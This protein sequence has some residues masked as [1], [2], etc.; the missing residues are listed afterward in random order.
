[1]SLFFNRKSNKIHNSNLSYFIKFIFF[2]NMEIIVFLSLIVLIDMIANKHNHTFD[3]SSMKRYS[4]S[5]QTKKIIKGLAKKVTITVFYEKG[6]RGDND[7]KL[8]LYASES[9]YLKYKLLNLDRNP[10]IAEKYKIL[11]YGEVLIECNGKY[12]KIPS[13][14]ED[15]I[16]NAILWVTRNKENNIYFLKGHGEKNPFSANMKNSYRLFKEALELENYT[17]KTISLIRNNVPADASLLI[18]SG[19]KIDLLE[20]ELENL[21]QYIV[22]GGK[23]IAMIDPFTVPRLVEFFKKYGVFFGNDIIVDKK[24]RL[25]GGS[26]LSPVA[27]LYYQR[28]PITREFEMGTL[29][30]LVRS[31]EFKDESLKGIHGMSLVRTHPDSWAEVDKDSIDHGNSSYQKLEDKK[32]PV[33]VVV[34]VEK[35]QEQ[36]KSDNKK[37]DWAMCF[38]GDSDFANNSNFDILGNKTLI[39]NVISWLTEDKKLI[40]T[41]PQSKRQLSISNL[42]LTAKQNII[43]FWAVVVV[44]PALILFIGILIYIRRLR[45]G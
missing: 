5:D 15:R 7:Q 9:P 3:F 26:Y 30:S 39:L 35:A 4:L 34:L 31:V 19:P 11:T 8:R 32:G 16:V 36:N 17:V 42:F 45:Y 20:E 23:I 40:F 33:S 2:A 25:F 28:H 18:L 43:I 1:M 41:R 27:S 38:F 10:E 21:A 12:K 29:F 44:E 6:M 37:A 22:R 24:N 13:T 14:K